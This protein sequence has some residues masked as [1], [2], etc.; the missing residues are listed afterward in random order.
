MANKTYSP[1]NM[2]VHQL[3]EDFHRQEISAGWRQQK[4]PLKSGS[5][6]F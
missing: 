1:D 5:K 2:S 6:D 3:I 4:K